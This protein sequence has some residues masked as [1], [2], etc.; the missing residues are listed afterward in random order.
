MANRLGKVFVSPLDVVLSER[1]AVQPEIIYITEARLAIVQD[2]IRG[3]PDLVAEIISQGSWKRDR[4]EK[5][6]LYEQFGIPEY[7]IIDPEARIIEVF[8]LDKGSYRSHSRAEPGQ[9]E[10]SEE[11]AGFEVNWEQLKP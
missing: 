2:V 8:V 3:A 6:D 7:W 10:K 11:L 5:K 1:R 4:V 9:A